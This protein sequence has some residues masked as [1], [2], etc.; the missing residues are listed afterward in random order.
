MVET[1][2]RLAMEYVVQWARGVGDGIDD[3]PYEQRREVLRPLLDGTAIDGDNKVKSRRG[4]ESEGV[5]VTQYRHRSSV[6]D[7]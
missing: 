4:L 5:V 1:E 2:K 6:I 3:M 7:C